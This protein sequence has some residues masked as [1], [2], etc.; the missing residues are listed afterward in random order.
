ME[1]LLVG[2]LTISAY[3]LAD[4]V[5]S[6]RRSGG[7]QMR[8]FYPVFVVLAC[9]ILSIACFAAQARAASG[10]DG[11]IAGIPEQK[12]PGRDGD[13]PPKLSAEEQNAGGASEAAI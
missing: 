6:V 1:H 10:L 4:T 2:L 13:A 5:T 11:M 8:P 7:E 12:K 3:F 9:S